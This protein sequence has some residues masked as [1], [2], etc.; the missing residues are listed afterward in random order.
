MKKRKQ[1]CFDIDPDMHAE[2]KILAIRRGISL[3]NWI[4]RALVSRIKKEHL[5][6]EDSS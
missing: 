6:Q 2:I 4:T 3:N 5:K 1:L